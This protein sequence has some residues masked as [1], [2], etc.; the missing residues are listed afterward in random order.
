MI[1]PTLSL[2]HPS[3]THRGRFGV[4]RSCRENAT[5]RTFVAKIVPY[6]AEGKRRVL[7]EYEVLRT[8]HHERLMSLHEAY[9]TPR[10]LVLIAESCGNRE[11]LCG[12]SDRFR[13]SEDDVATYVVQLLQGLDY[14][15]GHHVLHL[16]IKPDNLLLAADNALKIVDFGSAQPYN[17]QALKP[18]GH[19]TGTLEFMA[20]EMV[21]GDPI[22]SATDIW[23]AGVLTYIMLSGYS[24]FYEPD[25]QET[26]ARIVGGRFDAFQLYPNTSQSAT[27]FLR[28]VLSVHPWSRPSLQDCLAHP[29]LQDAYLM[30]LRRQTLTFTTNRLKEFLG[31]QRRRRAEA[32][33]RH[34]V[35]LRSYPGSP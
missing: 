23:G 1:V 20:P 22:G 14:L 31:E 15:H 4:V 25:P 9:I 13:Y 34:K 16:D 26:E 3:Y 6:A 21:K 32:A 29:W 12:L 35:L 30:K 18:L 24:P 33:T 19:R 8:L 11:L 7:Q 28:K 10:Y 17:P 5:G 27:L 2:W